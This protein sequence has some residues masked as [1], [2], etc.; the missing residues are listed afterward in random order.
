MAPL[1]TVIG[2]GYW[3][4]WEGAEHLFNLSEV[5]QAFVQQ[6]L[7]YQKV[8]VGTFPDRQPGTP[9]VVIG[10]MDSHNRLDHNFKSLNSLV[11]KD[12]CWRAKG[13]GF[14]S[15]SRQEYA[16]SKQ[17]FP[18]DNAD[19]SIDPVQQSPKYQR[20]QSLP[21]KTARLVLWV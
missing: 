1:S 13:P 18:S 12:L 2:K 6:P 19:H 4:T 3:G 16:L 14:E 10:G 8:Q 20:I 21:L 11:A 17:W 9:F 15:R 7:N 5:A